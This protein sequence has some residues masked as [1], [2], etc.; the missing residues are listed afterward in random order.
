VKQAIFAYVNSARIRSWNQL[1]LSNKGNV[2]CSMKQR[3]IDMA[4][5]HDWQASTNYESD[6]RTTAPRR[7]STPYTCVMR[8]R[9]VL[10]ARKL[11][12][13]LSAV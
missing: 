5:T 11:N 13:E 8:T 7:P 6:A 9:G 3:D 4:R 2:S 1:V 10:M 12:A